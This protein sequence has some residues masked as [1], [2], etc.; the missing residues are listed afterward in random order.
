MK[1]THSNFEDTVNRITL[2]YIF[3]N[4][5]IKER[6]EKCEWMSKEELKDCFPF[7][8]FEILNE[9]VEFVKVHKNGNFSKGTTQG[10]MID[11]FNEFMR[12]A[13]FLRYR[14]EEK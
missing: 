3:E 9:I 7:V 10:N 1:I 4:G 2:E 8:D 13:K 5:K 11:Q 12:L 14:G 6:I